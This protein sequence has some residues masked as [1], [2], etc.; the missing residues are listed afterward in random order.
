MS[1]YTKSTCR[2]MAS[3]CVIFG[4]AAWTPVSA[5]ADWS[6]YQG[7][8]GHTGYVPG[9]V[10]PSNISLRWSA[11]ISSGALG[12]LGVG[13][14]GVYVKG[15]GVGI[16]AVDERTGAPIWANPY[17]FG[18]GGGAVYTTSAPAYA[19]GMVYYQTDNQGASL[20][21]GVNAATGA[22]V[23]ATSYGAQW[24]TY[25][26]PT[27]YGTAV[28]TGGGEYGGIY[29]YNSTTGAQKWFGYEGQYDG[30]TPAVDGKFAYSF[31]GS[32]STVPIY[33]QFRMI[34][35]ATGSTSFLVTDTNFQWNGYTMNSA[36][37][38]GSHN[39]AFSINEPGLVYPNHSAAGRLLS[40]S[41]QSDAT[42]SP[43]IA[44]VLSDHYTGQPTLANSVLYAND[45]GTLVALDELT[46]K[47]LWS[48]APPGGSITGT[49]IA[50]DNVLFVSTA[51]STYALDLTTHVPDWSYNISGTLALSDNTLFVAGTN[52][53]LY[54]LDLPE[55]S[56]V[57]PA[58]FGTASLAA[59][60]RRRMHC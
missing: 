19:N 44:W 47:S 5:L 10:S 20:F 39:D 33:G 16:S 46:G 2:Y 37:V 59:M 3:A 42:H 22:S 50:T 31:T 53:T 28:Y 41:T 32:G 30:W 40:F 18:V 14:N 25:L 56:M 35:L 54:A 43:Q 52:G 34:D 11:P 29:S 49:M 26:N 17:T 9:S 6:T 27:P 36:V 48:W 57:G 4:A 23:F 58:L 51:T 38:L 55:P 1:A 8:A 12:G 21:H 7:D 60:R 13:G 45:G 24:E 15:P